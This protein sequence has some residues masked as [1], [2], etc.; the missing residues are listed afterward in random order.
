[1]VR[2][3][4]GG[5]TD[6]WSAPGGGGPRLITREPLHTAQVPDVVADTGDRRY[7]RGPTNLVAAGDALA[8]QPGCRQWVTLTSF[9]APPSYCQATRAGFPL[10]DGLVGR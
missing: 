7:N 9:Q 2:T 3:E 4:G 10:M 1:M 8:Q 6:G 5:S